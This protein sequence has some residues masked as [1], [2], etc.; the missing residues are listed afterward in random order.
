MEFGKI[1]YKKFLLLTA[2]VVATVFL[3]TY[4]I[5][6]EWGG[7]SP[8]ETRKNIEAA[9]EG[10]SKSF[11]L[12]GLFFASLIANATII[13]P[14]PIDFVVPIFGK[15]DFFGF[16]FLSPLLVAFVVSIG[17]AIGEMSGY[18]I[19][20]FGVKS[21]EKM[22]REEIRQIAE[23]EREIN[24]YGVAVVFV[25]ALTP[26][27]FD[28]IGVAAGLIKFDYKKF[29]LA[30]FAGKLIRYVLLAYLGLFFMDYI[31]DFFFGLLGL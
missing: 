25:G 3:F 14:L 29:F 12:P 6:I 16:G 23:K 24:K 9:F 22:K 11:G 1:S 8:Q 5:S 10:F 13:L 2:L 19:G 30:C 18:L 15:M 21:I 26:I 31:A 27:P 17:A 4:A 20:L 28:L 7:E